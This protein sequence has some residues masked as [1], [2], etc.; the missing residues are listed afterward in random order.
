MR[1]SRGAMQTNNHMRKWL[2]PL[3]FLG[4]LFVCAPFNFISAS[5][6]DYGWVE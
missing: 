6:P 1:T 4:A 5:P 3:S 2:W